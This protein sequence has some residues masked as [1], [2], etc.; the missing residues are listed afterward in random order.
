MKDIVITPKEAEPAF[1]A[2]RACVLDEI[3]RRF[4]A[5]NIH[6]LKAH[7]PDLYWQLVD[8]GVRVE[9]LTNPVRLESV[10]SIVDEFA[11]AAFNIALTQEGE[12]HAARQQ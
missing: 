11:A 8:C 3:L 2:A 7:D 10:L 1:E 6:A 5:F 9:K 4:P 12:S